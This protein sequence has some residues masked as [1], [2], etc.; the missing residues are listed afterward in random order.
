MKWKPIF[1]L[2]EILYAGFAGIGAG[3][4]FG[5]SFDLDNFTRYLLGFTVFLVC[6]LGPAVRQ[7]WLCLERR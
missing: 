5:Y 2:L 3:Y 7:E 6:I 1:V 4:A